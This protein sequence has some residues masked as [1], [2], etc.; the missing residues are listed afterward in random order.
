M[1]VLVLGAV[2]EWLTPPDY[3]ISAFFAAAPMVAAPVLSA[4]ATVAVGAAATGLLVLLMRLSGGLHPMEAVTQ[5]ITVATVAVLAVFFNRVVRRSDERLAS[6]RSVAEAVQLAVLPVPP[7]RLGPLAVAARYQAAQADTRIGGDFYAIQETPHGVRLLLGDVR[8]KGMEAVAAVTVLLGAFREAAE[9]EDSLPAVADRLDQALRRETA[10]RPAAEADE[11]FATA[12][13]VEIPGPGLLRM[14]SRGHP[15][16]FLVGP[17]DRLE[18]LE[19]VAPALPLGMEDLQL[20]PDRTGCAMVQEHHFPV[21]ATLLLFTDGL[22]EAR[23]ASGCFFPVAR[24]LSK[25]TQ[26]KSEPGFLLD[27]LVTEVTR[28][29]GGEASDDLALLAAVHMPA[30]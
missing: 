5:A 4:R 2:T 30:D 12:V 8:G 3:I 1:A 9:H 18:E 26:L 21:G 6:I 24:S 14:V 7:A 17:G 29:T 19:P 16:P 11:V 15:G 22:T 25:W 13:F 23:D 20:R 27:T 28:Y 10:R